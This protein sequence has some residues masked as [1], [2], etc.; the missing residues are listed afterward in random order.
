MYVN[1][2]DDPQD[3]E[4]QI[5]G[6]RGGMK[7]IYPS[8]DGNYPTHPG[9]LLVLG[10]SKQVVLE[11]REKAFYAEVPSSDL[12]VCLISENGAEIKK[13]EPWDHWKLGQ[14]SLDEHIVANRWTFVRLHMD[15][16]TTSGRFEVWLRPLGGKEVKVVEWIDGVTPDFS[17][18]IPAEK[19]GGYRVFRIPTTMGSFGERAHESDDC[20]IYLD[21]FAMAR[22]EDALSEYSD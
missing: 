7:W 10:T 2:Y 20:W 4:D 12:L 14:T 16:S 6:F 13:A 3:K 5:S 9:W 11:D 15:T 17:W 22:S 8:V 19:L 21:D 18:K 1:N